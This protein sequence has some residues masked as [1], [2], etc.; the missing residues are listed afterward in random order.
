MIVDSS[1]LVA[2]VLEEA[3]YESVRAKLQGSA[4]PVGI[5]APTAGEL[6]LVLSRRLDRDAREV[7]LKLLAKFDVAVIPFTDDHW[8]MAVDAFWRF[9]K[10]RHRAR[11]NLGDCFS[12]AT[13]R[14]ARQPLLFVG[15]D[16]GHTDIDVA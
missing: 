5:G 10:G 8:R 3:G 15:D 4:R 1:A 9:G 12:Y 16:F 11:L 2:I 6:G 7:V 13:A 14:L